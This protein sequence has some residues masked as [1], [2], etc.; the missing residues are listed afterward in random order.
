MDIYILTPEGFALMERS[1]EKECAG[2]PD[3]VGVSVALWR[4]RELM[5]GYRYAL[6]NGY[7]GQAYEERESQP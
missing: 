2:M 1:V 4:L 7:K 3:N 6:D 5:K